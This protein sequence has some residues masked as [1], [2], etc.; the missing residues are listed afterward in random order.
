[1]PPTSNKLKGDIA[2]GSFI[3]SSHLD[4]QDQ[5]EIGS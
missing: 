5:L 4:G 1:M 2:F 3:H